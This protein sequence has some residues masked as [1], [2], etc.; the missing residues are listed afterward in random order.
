MLKQTKNL[1][2]DHITLPGD[3]PELVQEAYKDS[4]T[5][6]DDW[7]TLQMNIIKQQGKAEQFCIPEPS[8]NEKKT[9]KGLLNTSYP[10]NTQAAEASVRDGLRS[11]TVLVMKRYADD[12]IGFLPWVEGGAKVPRDHKPSQ[13]EARKIAGQK[14]NLPYVF[15]LGSNTAKVIEELETINRNIIPEWQQA[16]FLKGEL[17]L[18]LD[19]K[20][21]TDLCGF[22]LSYD[23]EKG[24]I[25]TNGKEDDER[26][27]RN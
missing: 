11:I 4:E 3:I 7:N 21:Q 5:H 16:G 22:H 6:E 26:N 1:L 23:R 20:N 18:L 13:E 2:P 8:V 9:I 19:E 24:L 25:V 17:V 14:I 15:N 12:S 27:E 10:G